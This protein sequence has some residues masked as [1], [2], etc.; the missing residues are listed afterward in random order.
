MSVIENFF[1]KGNYNVVKIVIASVIAIAIATVYTFTRPVFVIDRIFIVSIILIFVSIHF[2]IKLEKIYNFIYKY[3]YYIAAIILFICTFF[4]Y[5]F[6]SIGT[7]NA[8]IQG[9]ANGTYFSPVL[10]EYRSIRS[11]EWVVNTPIFV[12]QGMDEETPYAYYNNNLRGT[13]TDMFSIV[14]P[15]VNDILVIAKPFNIG[16]LLLGIAKGIS[17]LW[18]GKW[19]ALALVAFEFF[20]MI[21]GSKKLLSMLGMILLVFSA[22]TQWWNITEMMLWGMLA[23][24]LADKYL[25]TDKLSTKLICG[26]GIFISAISFIFMM[27]PAWQIPFIYI[28][29]AIFISLVLKNRKNYKIHKKDIFIIGLVAMGVI[30]IVLRYLHMSNDAL[31]ATLN[32]DYPGERFEI[33]GGGA[34]VLFS[35][36]YSF[37]FPY[38]EVGNPCELAGMLSFYPIPMILSV[39]YLIRNKDRK[40]HIGFLLPLLALGIVFSIFS[41]FKTNEVFAK[42]TLLYMSTG[43]RIAIPLGFI[44]IV[45]LVYLMAIISKNTKILRNN[46]AKIVTIILGTLIFIIAV[47]TAPAGLIG[48]FKAYGC[49]MIL[50][51]F[52]YLLFTINNDTNKKYLVFGLIGMAL[53]TGVFVN[54]IQKGISVLTDKPLAKE[55]QAIVKEEPEDNL[56]I[57]ESTNFYIPNYLLANGAKVINSTNIYPNFGLYKTILTEDE[58]NNSDIRKIYNRYAHISMEL[59]ENDNEVQLLYPDSIKIY[60][61]PVK[62]KEL[63]VK[64][65]VTVRE[66]EKYDTGTVTFEKIYDEQGLFI[67]EIN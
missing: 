31:Q 34:K 7:Y 28:Y 30:G 14:S 3:R 8:V 48:V 47:K 55:I 27:Y 11:D 42:L 32:T 50:L 51:S 37:L 5:S 9:E 35:Y 6:S 44:Q 53:I 49:G 43:M 12:S 15:A 45:L 38:F 65:I 18:V 59:T 20:M 46:I 41:I 54:P 17:I 62:V 22:S 39:I 26:L 33:G 67:Y 40:E 64:Y 1:K 56:W 25:K 61:T 58:F 4:E 13:L 57:T 2:I 24:V 21:T 19:L 16:F 10:G 60:L 29:I 63:G 23:L 36:V 52:I 66:L